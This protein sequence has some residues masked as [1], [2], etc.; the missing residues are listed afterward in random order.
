MG[1]LAAHDQPSYVVAEQGAI[2]IDGPAG[3]AIT[4][5]AAAAEETARRLLAAVADARR[6]QA[7]QPS[8]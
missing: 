1:P 5:T 7:Q 2:I 6:Q 3:V 8:A 4:M